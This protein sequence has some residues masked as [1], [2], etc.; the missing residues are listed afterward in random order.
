MWEI[1]KTC[2]IQLSITV[3]ASVSIFGF[4]NGI[5]IKIVGQAMTHTCIRVVHGHFINML[6][7]KCGYDPVD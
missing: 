4:N 6:N 1:K 3:K 5:Y 2:S 7:W